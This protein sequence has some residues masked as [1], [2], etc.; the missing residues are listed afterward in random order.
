MYMQTNYEKHKEVQSKYSTS[1]KGK[2]ASKRGNLIY[3]LR[4]KGKLLDILG[5]HKC[6]KCGCIDFRVLQFDYIK[7]YGY[8]DRKRIGSS[9]GLIQYY[10]KH[11]EEAK[12][13]LQV[14][15]ANC[16]I[17]KQYDNKE[18]EKAYAKR[19]QNDI[20]PNEH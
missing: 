9:F 20:S 2:L 1:N 19:A 14:L 3:K 11:P 5:G 12:K 18:C 10:I 6:K 4:Q 7:G 16:N 15:C 13:M 8:I 17:I